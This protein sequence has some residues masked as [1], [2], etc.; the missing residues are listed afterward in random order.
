[1][2]ITCGFEIRKLDPSSKNFDSNA[3][4]SCKNRYFDMWIND[5][6]HRY[7]GW[8]NL[9]PYNSPCGCQG[10]IIPKEALLLHYWDV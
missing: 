3:Y 4:S 2:S 8:K 9:K 1:M 7:C 5:W 10:A 6:L